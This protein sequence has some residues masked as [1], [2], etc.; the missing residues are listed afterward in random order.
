MVEEKKKVTDQK[1]LEL[2]ESKKC[3]NLNCTSIFKPKRYWQ[4]Y[5][6][7]KCRYENWNRTNP[8]VKSS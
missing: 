1:D 8:R 3:L 2:A 7:S 5:C 4:N 6:S